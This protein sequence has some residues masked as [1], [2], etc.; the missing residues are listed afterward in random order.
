MGEGF[1][2]KRAL[3]VLKVVEFVCCK[4]AALFASWSASSFPGMP[5]WPETHWITRCPLLLAIS[6]Q[7]WLIS[8]LLADAEGSS[9]VLTRERKSVQIVRSSS[10]LLLSIAVFR[11]RISV[12]KD[13]VSLR[14]LIVVILLVMRASGD[15]SV[16]MTAAP[17]SRRPSVQDPSV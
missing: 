11:P 7:I 12:S 5:A 3:A 16:L 4:H 8:V 17:P 9:K 6:S 15:P 13:H 2:L 10:L 14:L 1:F